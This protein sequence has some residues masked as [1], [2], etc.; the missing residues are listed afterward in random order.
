MYSHLKCIVSLKK[1]A[2]RRT[3]VPYSCGL[4]WSSKDCLCVLTAGTNSVNTVRTAELWESVFVIVFEYVVTNM[5]DM[6]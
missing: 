6:I 3:E 1:A 5:K 2:D 4:K